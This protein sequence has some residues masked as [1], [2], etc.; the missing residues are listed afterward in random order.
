M[1]RVALQ[2][3]T[4]RREC[5]RDLADALRRVG[6][7]GYDGV[8][9]F[10]LHGH[11]AAE[12]RAWLD[13]AQLAA[14]GRHA[15]L[16]LIEEELPALAAELEILGSDRV[17]IGW[18]DP[19]LLSDPAPVVERIAAAAHAAR[20]AGLRLGFH[21]HWSEL[22]RV[23]GGGTFLDALRELPAELLWLELDLGWIW[24]AGADPLDEL[25]RTAGR[26]PLV[27]AKDY[28]SREGRDDVPVGDGVVGYERLLPAAV[29]AGAEWLVVEED[30]VGDDPFG[31]VERSLDAV[32]RILAAA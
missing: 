29:E 22:N 17:A 18:I 26:C 20:E 1:A 9:L 14:A 24:Q 2:L 15:R 30:E 13:E 12:V 8:E 32:R 10:E 19:D 5:E 21:N 27:H 28:R 16:E 23:D 31:A 6:R 7:Q 11:D 3:Y 25:R 4:I